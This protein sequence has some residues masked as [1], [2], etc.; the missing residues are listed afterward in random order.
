MGID[1]CF[2]KLGCKRSIMESLLGGNKVT[3]DNIMP[4]LGVLEQR[5]MEILRLQTD[6]GHMDKGPGEKVRACSARRKS[7]VKKLR[8]IFKLGTISKFAQMLARA[9]PPDIHVEKPNEE[10]SSFKFRP[11]DRKEMRVLA[12]VLTKW[13]KRT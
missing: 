3:P 2:E 10:E 6:S 7:S 11:L 9:E 1:S 12:P 13:A 5:T 4:Y 8:P